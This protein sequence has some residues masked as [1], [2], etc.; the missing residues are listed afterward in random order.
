MLTSAQIVFEVIRGGQ[1][2]VIEAREVVPGDVLVVEDGAVLSLYREH[3]I[4]D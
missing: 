2:Q 4:A 3:C 1:E